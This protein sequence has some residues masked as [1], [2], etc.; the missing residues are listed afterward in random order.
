MRFASSLPNA[1]GAVHRTPSCQSMTKTFGPESSGTTAGMCTDG[2]SAKLFRK[3]LKFL[4]SWM[5]SSSSNNFSA[6]SSTKSV[7]GH[8][9]FS[10]QKLSNNCFA[11]ALNTNKSKITESLVFGLKTFIATSRL[12]FFSVPRY[13]CP[14]L[15]A[16]TGSFVNVSN[17]SSIFSPHCDSII[18][19]A[20]DVGN[21]GTLS[22]KVV[23]SSITSSGTKSGLFAKF[24]PSFTN[25]GPKLVN[26]VFTS[27]A[28]NLSFVTPSALF[29]AV[30]R[31]ILSNSFLFPFNFENFCVK[32]NTRFANFAG[33]LNASRRIASGSY[34]VTTLQKFASNS[35]VSFVFFLAFSLESFFCSVL[36][37]TSSPA[38]LLIAV[39]LKSGFSSSSL[40]SSLKAPSLILL[41][42]LLVVVV[43]VRRS[44]TRRSPRPFSPSSLLKR[45]LLLPPLSRILVLSVLFENPTFC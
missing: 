4:P 29:S 33:R 37:S 12:S 20:S 28:H 32:N 6:N 44:K 27:F 22:C 39:P 1:F 41:L 5:K 40:S 16:A 19:L 45:G 14:M 13:T 26:V 8:P 30:N 43:V 3:S 17:T 42:L 36:T 21:A 11:A 38:I 7:A 25:S 34:R 31:S 9:T 10:K 35:T 18:S 15:A 2:S 23:N 24:C